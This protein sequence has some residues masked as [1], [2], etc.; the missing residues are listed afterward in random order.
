MKKRVSP[1]QGV[2]VGQTADL[3][4]YEQLRFVVPTDLGSGST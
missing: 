4:Y 3:R 2:D 1:S